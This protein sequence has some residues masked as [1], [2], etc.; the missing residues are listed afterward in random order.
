MLDFEIKKMLEV[1]EEDDQVFFK[2]DSLPERY[3]INRKGLVYD[4]KCSRDVYPVFKDGY[5]KVN[6]RINEEQVTYDV[7]K[8]LLM[9]FSPMHTTTDVYIKTLKVISFDGNLCNLKLDNLIWRVPYGGVECL[10]YLGYYSIPGSP[11]L[12]VS[13]DGQF[14]DFRS[15]FVKNVAIPDKSN[16]YPT[17]SNPSNFN[18]IDT[19]YNTNLVHRLIALAFIPLDGIRDRFYVNHIDGNKL[20]YDIKNLEWVTYKENRG[21]AVDMGL[22]V[23][24]VRLMAIDIYTKER[25]TFPSL[26]AASRALGLHAFDISKA[27]AAYREQ[28]KVICP[29]WLFLEQGDTIPTSFI[30]TQRQVEP[31]GIR[32]FLVEKDGV[33]EYISGTRNLS[34]YVKNKNQIEQQTKEYYH[35]FSVNGYSIKEVYRQDVPADAYKKEEE[36]RGGK[37]QKAIRVTDLTSNSVITYPSTDHFATLVGAKRKTIQRGM[38]YN[39]GIWRNFKIEYMDKQ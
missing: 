28:G 8:L 6:L 37:E 36:N 26:Q 10:K 19:P 1:A 5:L 30:R 3:S 32:W 9:A 7:R 11:N 23:Q 12:V 35:V 34:R 13:K 4:Y 17:V 33:S 20:N 14:L 27:I 16:Q 38:L 39:D 21:H 18:N 15:G 25:R 2:I 24:S 22:C 29:P 31:T